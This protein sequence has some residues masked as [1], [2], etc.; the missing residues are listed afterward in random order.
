MN[1]N[2][3]KH[4]HCYTIIIVERIHILVYQ[5]LSE[6]DQHDQKLWYSGRKPLF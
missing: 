4:Y 2:G 1:E 5:K 6:K 3:H